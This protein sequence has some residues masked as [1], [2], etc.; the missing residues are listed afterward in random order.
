MYIHNNK[1]IMIYIFFMGFGDRIKERAKKIGKTIGDLGDDLADAGKKI[2]DIIGEA[3]EFVVDDVVG[4]VATESARIIGGDKAANKV[5]KAFEDRI[6]PAI[7]R[8]ITGVANTLNPLVHIG[9]IIDKGIIDGITHT[10]VEGTQD[11]IG[12]FT[13]LVAGED[14][15]KK[16][17]KVFDEK[18]Q[19]WVE[20]AV[21]AAGSS[22]LLIASGG[23]A[24]PLLI[25]DGL[26]IMAA[27]G[28]RAAQGEDVSKLEWGLASAS[29]AMSFIPGGAAA[30]KAGT[31]AGAKAGARAATKTGTKAATGVADDVAEAGIKTT[32]K[33]VAKST[34]DIADAGSK[35]ANKW[36]WSKVVTD[37]GLQEVGKDVAMEMGLSFVIMKG[38]EY[39]YEQ[40]AKK[41]QQNDPHRTAV[42]ALH[43]HEGDYYQPR[44][45]AGV[46]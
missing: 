8:S 36:D 29:A 4:T 10:V 20:I 35:A 3:A 23:A 11:Q 15:E 45:T 25:A 34:D 26:S 17:D 5:D 46:A 33:S 6:T 1:Q 16:F 12:S 9:H 24:A 39:Y 37:Q 41:D 2:S 44:F 43:G 28:I 40:Q 21:A 19:M 22:A 42:S 32:T 27:T 7:T 13:R 30:T 38:I 18:V 31:K 14:A